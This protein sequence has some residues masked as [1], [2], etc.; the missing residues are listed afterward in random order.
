MIEKVYAVNSYWDMT[1]IEGIAGYN[2]RKYY[3]N[4]I[5]SSDAVDNWTDADAYELTL[6]DDYIF[7]LTLE[8]WEY[9]RNWLNK[10]NKKLLFEIPHPAKYAEIRKILTVD[11]IFNDKDTEKDI[12]ELTEKN[13]RNEIIINEYLKNSKPVYKARGTFFGKIN[14]MDTKVE[15]E[16]VIKI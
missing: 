15:W 6:L 1:I 5:F 14:G 7:G 2:D 9:W 13:Y 8:N 3:F 16:N 4:C 11:E 12:I 10:F